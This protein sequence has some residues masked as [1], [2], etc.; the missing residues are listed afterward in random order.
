M[1]VFLKLL[2]VHTRPL[3]AQYRDKLEGGL[4]TKIQQQTYQNKDVAIT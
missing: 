2:G 4:L 3:A 1:K